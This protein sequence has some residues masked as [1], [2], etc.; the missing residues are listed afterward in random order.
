MRGLV[1]AAH[2]HASTIKPLVA[3]FVG[4]VV[5]GAGGVAGSPTV[6]VVLLLARIKRKLKKVPVLP[7]DV[8]RWPV[9]GILG[10][11]H[12]YY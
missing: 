10:V 4:S 7:S 8:E 11:Q 3:L 6:L 12:A 2:S 1:S 5:F 9:C